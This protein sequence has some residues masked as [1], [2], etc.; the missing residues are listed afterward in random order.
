MC[1]TFGCKSSPSI[2]NQVSEGLCW[3]L[4]NKVRVSS[5]LHLL[6]DFLLI[7]PRHDTSGSSLYKLKHLFN[8]L[9]VPLSAEKTISPANRLKFLGITLDTVEMKAFLATEKLVRIREI[10]QSFSASDGVSKQQLLS[11]LG[12]LNFAMCVIPQGRSC[13][14]RLLDAALSTPNLHDTIQLS[15]GCCSDLRFW[16]QLLFLFSMMT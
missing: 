4:L 7:D 2:F 12:H 6:D 5:V 16:A 13:I 10:I 9:G 11:L 3:I 1:L 14:S 8:H 15:D